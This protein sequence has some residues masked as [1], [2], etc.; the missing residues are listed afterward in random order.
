MPAEHLND[1]V[2]ADPSAEL[3][4]LRRQ[5]DEVAA[6]TVRLTRQAHLAGAELEMRRRGFALLAG[7]GN[8]LGA[9]TEV[10]PALASVLALVET[11]LH[12]QRTV[13]LRRVGA[14]Y[15]PFAWT[16]FPVGAGAAGRAVDLSLPAPLL[17]SVG[18]VVAAG[19]AGEPWVSD[20]R[21]LLDAPALLVVPVGGPDHVLAVGRLAGRH[22]F[23]APFDA[24]D[25]D[26]LSAVAGLVAAGVQNTRFAALNEVRR[27]LAPSVVAELMTGRL[28]REEVQERREVTL[29]AADLVGFTP[30]AERLAPEELARTLDTYLSDMTSLA[31][32]HRGTVNTFAGDGLM[33]IFGAP[34]V[35]APEE[36][37]WAAAQA[38]FAMQAQMPRLVER[39]RQHVDL[40]L[41]LRV[42]LNTGCCSVG[43]FGSDTH[44]TYAAIGLPTN[45]AAR[46]ESAAAPGEVL[47]SPSTLALL[48]DRVAS[49]SRGELMLK[50]VAAPLLA[51]AIRP[52]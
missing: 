37:A 16:G 2:A 24:V 45:V 42:G 1:G 38:A 15:E 47:A 31:Y 18:A 6:E 7:L 23:F 12:V 26:T 25:L 11:R 5:L 20:L 43:V 46:L 51:H 50:G 3:R 10:E 48:A 41:E 35:M 17:E 9:H 32:A 33:V 28:R 40:T 52:A 13:A 34:E 49:S 19:A 39:L 36:H 22:G 29:L 44:R 8:T 27:F 30:L 4:Y 14:T 21:A